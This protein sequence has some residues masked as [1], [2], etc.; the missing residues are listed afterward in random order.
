MRTEWLERVQ[1]LFFSIIAILLGVIFFNSLGGSSLLA[2]QAIL[3][4][5]FCLGY[6]ILHFLKI[7]T[8]SD[9]K[10]RTPYINKFVL[11]F[12]AIQTIVFA[13]LIKSYFNS[14]NSNSWFQKL[15]PIYSIIGFS[16]V[17]SVIFVLLNL[18][19]PARYRM[20]EL[21]RSAKLRKNYALNDLRNNLQV[22]TELL[23]ATGFFPEIQ[24][25]QQGAEISAVRLEEA[26]RLAISKIGGIEEI[27]Q[28]MILDKYLELLETKDDT[29][30]NSRSVLSRWASTTWVGIVVFYNV[31]LGILNLLDK[32]TSFTN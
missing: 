18:Y 17:F 2:K 16:L 26:V 15:N 23:L 31:V 3:L 20:E 6:N 12:T 25:A 5:V 29:Y 27:L 11:V 10:E 30:I 19:L 4:I 9:F 21:G 24:R 8:L 28:Y 1:Y 7:E 14:L 22:R 13:V 32:L